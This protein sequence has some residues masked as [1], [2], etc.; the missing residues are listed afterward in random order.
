VRVVCV[1]AVL[2]YLRRSYAWREWRVSPV[3]VAIGAVA[4]AAWMVLTHVTTDASGAHV[5]PPNSQQFDPYQ[6]GQPSAALWLLCRV[7]GSVVT[8]PIAEELFFRGFVIRRCIAEDTESVPEGQFSWFSVLA[9]SAA[10]GFLHGDA[11]LAGIVAGMLF[12]AALYGR[13]RLCDAVVA[14]ATTN[15]LLSGYVLATGSWSQ[16]G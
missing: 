6:L 14:H 4:F 9:S 1:A 12:A 8:V 7:I 13:R 5:A 10:F 11:W 2:F 15:A 16:W 3:A